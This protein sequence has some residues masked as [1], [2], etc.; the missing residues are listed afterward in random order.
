MLV[1]HFLIE[2]RDVLTNNAVNVEKKNDSTEL[3]IPD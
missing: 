2:I 3:G 1:V